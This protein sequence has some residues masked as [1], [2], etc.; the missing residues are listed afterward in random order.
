MKVKKVSRVLKQESSSNHYRYVPE[1]ASCEGIKNGLWRLLKRSST[2][3]LSAGR[4]DTQLS[5]NFKECRKETTNW[6]KAR[7]S[8]LVP[9]QPERVLFTAFKHWNPSQYNTV[10]QTISRLSTRFFPPCPNWMRSKEVEN[11]SVQR[12]CSVA[13]F[14]SLS[15]FLVT[16]STC[17]RYLTTRFSLLLLFLSLRLCMYGKKARTLGPLLLSLS[18][19]PHKLTSCPHPKFWGLKK[20]EGLFELHLSPKPIMFPF[21]ALD[22]IWT[23]V[24]M[25]RGNK[26]TTKRDQL[27]DSLRGDWADPRT[28]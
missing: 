25:Q 17:Q 26:W 22:L 1:W 12:K 16:D 5:V 11:N 21:G 20:Y 14:L 8:N 6:W 24:N 3:N 19:L 9:S 18:C 23:K 2:H 10:V 27:E 28:G 7:L 15:A 4:W 13:S